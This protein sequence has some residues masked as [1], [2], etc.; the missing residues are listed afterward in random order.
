MSLISSR[1]YFASIYYHF[2][3]VILFRPLIKFSPTEEQGASSFI[4]PRT[5]CAE[6]VHSIISLTENYDHLFGFRQ[7]PSLFSHIVLAAGLMQVTLDTTSKAKANN[8]GDFCVPT[9]TSDASPVSPESF[10]LFSS[11]LSFGDQG[12]IYSMSQSPVSSLGPHS[13]NGTTSFPGLGYGA[14]MEVDDDPD[15]TGEIALAISH[16][17]AMRPVHPAAAQAR[18][19]LRGMCPGAVA[20]TDARG[21]M[22]T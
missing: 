2:S 18:S 11:P 4:S 7:A 14:E 21:C 16:L 17:G 5:I 20:V 3:L 1:T 22:K 10:S 15:P 19:I 6:S 12:S 13:F 9:P 8:T